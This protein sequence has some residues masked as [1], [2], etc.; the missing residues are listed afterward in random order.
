MEKHSLLIWDL[1]N[2]NDYITFCSGDHLN[3]ESY[4]EKVPKIV[5]DVPD[6]LNFNV[7]SGYVKSTPMKNGTDWHG[8]QSVMAFQYVS[9]GTQVL[10]AKNLTN[11]IQWV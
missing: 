6:F 1:F 5:E 8:V 2:H 3:T 11:S 9:P 7:S 10:L 4:F